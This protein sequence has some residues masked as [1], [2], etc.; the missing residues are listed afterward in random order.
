MCGGVFMDRHIM[1]LPM[2]FL[3]FPILTMDLAGKTSWMCI[4]VAE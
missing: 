2:T 1:Y 4:A 3:L